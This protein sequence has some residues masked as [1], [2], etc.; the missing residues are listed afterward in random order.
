M[1]AA[2]R[3]LAIR[4]YRRTR[5]KRAHFARRLTIFAITMVSM[6]TAILLGLD[7][8]FRPNVLVVDRLVIKGSFEYYDPVTLQPK[9]EAELGRNFFTIDLEKIK[10]IVDSETWVER[11]VVRR[12]WPNT[13][14]VELVES[15]PVMRWESGGWLTLDGRI[16][17]LPNFENTASIT[18][19]GPR[20]Q[21]MQI[22]QRTHEWSEVLERFG[23][24]LESLSVSD[25]RS[26]GL[27]VLEDK[28]ENGF[29]IEVA[30]GTMDLEHRFD[31]FLLAFRKGLLAVENGVV[32][33]DVRYPDGLAIAGVQ[34]F[35]R[36]PPG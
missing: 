5:I 27:V 26:W 28:P 3:A 17:E 23:L 11:S 31:R 4:R 6:V 8:L 35:D 2:P 13:L 19:H 21:S 15:V 12:E 1:T 34:S 30:L 18:V 7:Y 16:V 20:R 14:M 25:W 36:Q 29:R 32:Y 9:I 33:V 22:M 24:R 10:R